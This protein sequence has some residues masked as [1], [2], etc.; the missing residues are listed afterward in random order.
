[1]AKTVRMIGTVAAIAASA[2]PLPSAAECPTAMQA[3]QIKAACTQETPTCVLLRNRIQKSCEFPIAAQKM[4]V[5]GACGGGAASC[6]E[7]GEGALVL[8]P[9]MR[10]Q[11]LIQRLKLNPQQVREALSTGAARK[12]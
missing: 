7:A 8:E 1:M 3:A 12:E 4:V 2:W 11:K 10:D 9:Q 6:G 5:R